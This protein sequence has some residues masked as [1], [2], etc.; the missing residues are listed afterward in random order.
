MA[1]H[2][3]D[4]FKNYKLIWDKILDKIKD[5]YPIDVLFMYCDEKIED[6]YI[7]KDNNLISKC[8]ENYWQALLK[9]VIS[10]FKHF[11]KNDYDLIF[12]TNLSTIVNFDKFYEF[13][14][15]IDTENII[16]QGFIGSYEKY[17]FC[18]GA[19]MLLNKKSV[20]IVLNNLDKIDDTWTDDIFI[21][22]ILNNLNNIQPS[23]GGLNRLDILKDMV[24]NDDIKNYTH[25]RIKIRQENKDIHYTNKVFE[26]L[27]G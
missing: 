12:K 21:G 16:Y 14:V 17:L 22:Y 20:E 9:K 8:K 24:I 6:E 15:K 4:V 7:I 25:I 10:G 23:M 5:K 26:I 13:C 1:H 19:G 27:Y 11:Q 3:D 18:S 2:E